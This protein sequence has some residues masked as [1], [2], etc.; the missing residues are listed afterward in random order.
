MSY[1]NC[2]FGNERWEARGNGALLRIQAKL[3][4]ETTAIS[5]IE[6]SDKINMDKR[7]LNISKSR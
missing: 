6:A 5:E 2:Y 3:R 7:K 4:L 1:S